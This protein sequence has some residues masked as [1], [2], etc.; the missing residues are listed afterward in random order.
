MKNYKASGSFEDKKNLGESSGKSV[1]IKIDEDIQQVATDEHH[2]RQ[3]A[4]ITGATPYHIAKQPNKQTGQEVTLSTSNSLDVLLRPTPS[5]ML[6]EVEEIEEETETIDIKTQPQDHEISYIQAPSIQRNQPAFVKMAD[7]KIQQVMMQSPLQKQRQIFMG[8]NGQLFEI[9]SA[10][11]KQQPQQPIVLVLPNSK[12]GETQK[13]IL[14]PNLLGNSN[15]GQQIIYVIN[16]SNANSNDS[17]SKAS[18]SNM[19][20]TS[21]FAKSSSNVNVIDLAATRAGI[22]STEIDVKEE[23]KMVKADVQGHHAY[24]SPFSQ[25]PVQDRSHQC[26]FC[27]KRFARSDECK[28]HERIHTDTRPFACTYCDRRFTRKDHLRTHTRCHTKEKPYKCPIC[29]R[30]FARSDE[31][32]RHLKIHIKRGETTMEEAKNKISQALRDQTLQRKTHIIFEEVKSQTHSIQGCFDQLPKCPP[33]ICADQDL[34]G[35]C[36]RSCGLCHS[37]EDNRIKFKNDIIYL[38]D[39]LFDALPHEYRPEIFYTDTSHIYEEAEYHTPDEDS[40]VLAGVHNLDH[41]TADGVDDVPDEVY[42]NIQVR[43][44]RQYYIHPE[45]NAMSDE[46]DIAVLELDE[47]LTLSDY[48]Q[49]ACLPSGEPRVNEYCEV[50]GWGASKPENANEDREHQSQNWLLQMF[51]LGTSYPHLPAWGFELDEAKQ[52]GNELK[53]GILQIVSQQAC[54]KQY[55]NDIITGNMFCAGSNAGVDTCLG[56]S[57]GP[58]VCHNPGD[59]RWEIT[60]VTSWGRGCGGK[61][62]GV[63]TKV[64]QYLDWLSHIEAGKGTPSRVDHFQFEDGDE[65]DDIFDYEAS[66][67]D[68]S[69]DFYKCG[70]EVELQIPQNGVPASGVITSPNYPKK[71]SSDEKC[72][73]LITAPAGFH[74]E[75]KFTFFKVEYDTSCRKDRVEIHHDG[76]GFYLCGN[77]IPEDTFTTTEKQM[78]IFFSSNKLINFP[79]FS[80]IYTIKRNQQQV[81]NIAASF[82]RADDQ[83]TGVETAINGICGRPLISPDR[84]VRILGGQPIRPT[85]WPWLGMLLEEDGEYIH[86]KCGVALICHQ[87]AIT[88][89]DCARELTYGEKYVHKVKFGNMRWDQASKHQEEILVK[90][91]IGKCSEMPNIEKEHP[92]FDGGYDYDIALIKFARPVA[93]NEYIQPICM[94]DYVHKK[95]GGFNCFAAGWG[96]NS[97]TMST[98]QAHSAKINIVN[99]GYCSQIYKKKYSTQQMGDGGAPLICEADNGEWFLHGIS[100]YGPGCNKRGDGPSVF[101]RPSVFLTFIEEATGGCVR[102]F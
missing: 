98:R 78:E 52:T 91:I 63:Y 72:R 6:E 4:Q 90:S 27:H 69:T 82:E 101:V 26:K 68:L 85:Q 99:D 50:A 37:P 17:Q 38:L 32:I 12:N 59:Q 23:D 64:V 67:D 29:D 22:R 53:S 35:L 51:E 48:V 92:L 79:G 73:W 36:A 31:R 47:P 10:E 71:Y 76:Q 2:A 60:G 58:L 70:F 89:G 41:L 28:R 7:G 83:P 87:W 54:Q 5:P 16:N 97:Q 30:S 18:G 100:I 88:S 40:M 15:N 57:G 43:N 55:E 1:T 61:F 25:V 81:S 84:M 21:G 96:M 39:Q 77:G 9:Q 75:L 66:G 34:M 14:P 20:S 33:C 95:K 3:A 19:G 45:Y 49:P 13:L 24:P 44:A 74:I 42:D 8:P 11:P 93:F 86:M 65:D 94:K 56:D 80:A 62:P 46:H 102:S